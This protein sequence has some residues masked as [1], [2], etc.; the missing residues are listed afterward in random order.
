[1]TIAA[2][3][4]SLLGLSAVNSVEAMIAW[5]ADLPTNVGSGIGFTSDGELFFGNCQVYDPILR[6]F[7]EKHRYP[8]ELCATGRVKFS[9]LSPDGSLLLSSIAGATSKCSGNSFSIDGISGRIR[10]RAPGLDFTNI[11]IHP[12]NRQFARIESHEIKA[13]ERTTGDPEQFQVIAIRNLD[14]SLVSESPPMGSVGISLLRFPGDGSRI[15][16]EGRIY[17]TIDW[18]AES[19]DESPYF[20]QCSFDGSS[21]LRIYDGLTANIHSKRSSQPIPVPDLFHRL[22]ESREFSWSQ[23]GRFFAYKGVQKDDS[24]VRVMRMGVV[25]LDRTDRAPP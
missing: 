23:D 7:D 13:S 4:L 22:V 15:E 1:M 6:K 20:E 9:T 11:A 12:N 16:I 8:K 2:F 5:Q 14:R 19:G 3:I 21:C 25:D 24:G 10:S 17:K 18:T